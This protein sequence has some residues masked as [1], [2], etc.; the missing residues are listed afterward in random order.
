MYR[1]IKFV[2]TILIL[3]GTLPSLRSVWV[4]EDGGNAFREWSFGLLSPLVTIRRIGTGPLSDTAW[5][6][7]Q[8]SVHPISWSGAF[9]VAGL[10]IYYRREI[11]RSISGGDPFERS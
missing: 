11:V 10:V 7:P 6:S 1:A 4:A 3:A 9:V 5:L 8:F 2:A